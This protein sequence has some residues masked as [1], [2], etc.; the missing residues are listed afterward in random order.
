MQV[1]HDLTHYATST[2]DTVRSPA[3]KGLSHAVVIFRVKATEV[4][5]VDLAPKT[6]SW[7]SDPS[8]CG[9]VIV[10]A[11]LVHL[12]MQKLRKDRSEIASHSRP[13]SFLKGA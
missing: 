3:S 13:I 11:H 8:A 1:S 9:K 10:I 7:V 2:G 5:R 12:T 6:G 4:V